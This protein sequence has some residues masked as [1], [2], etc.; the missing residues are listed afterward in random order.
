MLFITMVRCWLLP[1][2]IDLTNSTSAI[3]HL[4]RPVIDRRSERDGESC[5]MGDEM[6]EERAASMGDVLWNLE[7]ALQLQEAVIG[8]E[9]EDNS[10][11]MIGELP[12]QINNFSQGDTSVNV[13]E[14][15]D[16]LR[17]R[18]LMISLVFP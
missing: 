17:N 4:W 9:P 18:A 5:G 7:Y 6:A 13:R 8:G 2:L 16:Y 10:T 3:G 11:N 14:P 1:W 15:R 12:P